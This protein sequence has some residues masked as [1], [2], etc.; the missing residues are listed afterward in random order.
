MT[1]TGEPRQVFGLGARGVTVRVSVSCALGI[2]G[3]PLCK[4]SKTRG[5]CAPALRCDIDVVCD[6]CHAMTK[7]TNTT[8]NTNTTI[9]TQNTTQ[10][11][12]HTTHTQ[13][14]KHTTQQH[15]HT[16]TQQHNTNTQTTTQTQQ[17]NTNNTRFSNSK[18]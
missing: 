11:S 9:T 1:V 3:Q 10:T 12:T 8:K 6:G 16:N 5:P 17:H 13:T 7:Q 4:C 2:N 18:Y 14:H 15:T